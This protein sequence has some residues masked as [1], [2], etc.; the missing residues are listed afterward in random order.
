MDSLASVRERRASE[1]AWHEVTEAEGQSGAQRRSVN[2]SW[3]LLAPYIITY[4]FVV[5]IFK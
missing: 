3:R 5:V 2:H 1:K 4:K